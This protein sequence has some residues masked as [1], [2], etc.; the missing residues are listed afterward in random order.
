MKKCRRRAGGTSGLQS[1]ASASSPCFWR[2]RYH[3]VDGAAAGARTSPRSSSASTVAGR[4]ARP[5][6]CASTPSGSRF[7]TDSM[8]DCE[9]GTRESAKEDVVA[10]ATEGVE[11]WA[12]S[13]KK[14]LFGYAMGL[15]FACLLPRQ[16]VRIRV[17]VCAC[18]RACVCVCASVCV[19]VCG[20]VCPNVSCHHTRN[21]CVR[22]NKRKVK[23]KNDDL[24]VE[25]RMI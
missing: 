12:E 10:M 25:S 20:R 19:C 14:S 6:S 2:R 23:I 24:K 5:R 15:R 18:V 21:K 4:F 7:N 8:S 22:Q 3:A 13:E 1:T 16:G 17:C 9:V 11:D